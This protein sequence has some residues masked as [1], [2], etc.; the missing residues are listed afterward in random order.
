[1]QRTLIHNDL[2]VL[3][4][5]KE[6]WRYLRQHFLQNIDPVTGRATTRLRHSARLH[7]LTGA[8]KPAVKRM[9][10]SKTLQDDQLANHDSH[11]PVDVITFINTDWPSLVEVFR[12]HNI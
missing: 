10:Q 4:H 11:C 3:Q 9:Q 5:M 1:M 8:G 2:Q 6:S 7:L 12:N